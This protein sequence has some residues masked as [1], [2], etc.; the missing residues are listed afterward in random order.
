M[1]SRPAYYRGEVLAGAAVLTLALIGLGV[2]AA[3]RPAEPP[4]IDAR[5][6]VLDVNTASLDALTVLPGVGPVTAG[7]VVAARPFRALDDLRAVLGDDLFVA[8][9]P[10]LALGA[11]EVAPV[12]TR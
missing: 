9:R 5:P 2:R 1:T 12:S 7:R 11:S 8:L 4:A 10:H 6:V 3:L